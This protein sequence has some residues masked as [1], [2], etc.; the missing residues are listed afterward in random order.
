MFVFI[1]TKNIYSNITNL[2]TPFFRKTNV[3]SLTNSRYMTCHFVDEIFCFLPSLGENL[4]YCPQTSIT[5]IKTNNVHVPTWDREA[6]NVANLNQ[7]MGSQPFS[8]DNL[9]LDLVLNI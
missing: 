9:Y 8:L 2:N 5:P 7:A 4:I 6:Q 3:V 1:T